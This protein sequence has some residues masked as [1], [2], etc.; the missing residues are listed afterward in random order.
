MAQWVKNMTS[1]SSDSGVEG[2]SLEVRITLCTEASGPSSSGLGEAYIRGTEVPN[3]HKESLHLAVL[4][5]S[6]HLRENRMGESSWLKRRSKRLDG[7]SWL[8][9]F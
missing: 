3:F 5:Q 1:Y 7:P 9:D 2:S 8:A 6:S 4:V